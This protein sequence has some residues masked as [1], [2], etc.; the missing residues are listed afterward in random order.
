MSLE[1]VISER[2]GIQWI[3]LKGRLD[4]ATS[5]D[6]EKVISLQF[7]TPGD[8]VVMNFADLG[9]VSSA[10]LRV[11]L[12]AAKRARQVQGSMVLCSLQDHVREVL[13]ISG[14]LKILRVV[15]TP[16]QAVH[17]STA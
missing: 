2:H 10:G 7:Q 11:I 12:M 4:S 15:D 3:T 17:E 13:H 6:F 16:E 1:F 8:K 14:F 9:Y 5:A